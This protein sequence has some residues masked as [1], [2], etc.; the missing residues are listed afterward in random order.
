MHEDEKVVLIEEF[1]EDT[2]ISQMKPVGGI[3]GGI[4]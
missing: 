4:G 1:E 2:F 3:A